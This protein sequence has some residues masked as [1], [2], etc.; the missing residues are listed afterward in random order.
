MQKTAVII[1]GNPEL[2]E[3]NLD[4]GVFYAEL[5]DFLTELGFEVFLDPGAEF[6][7]PQEANVW[8]GHSR[9][10]DRLRFA[11]AG[12]MVIGI[13]VPQNLGDE[14]SEENIF[15]I[16]NHPEDEMVKRLFRDGEVVEGKSDSELDDTYHYVLSEEMK[17]ELKKILEVRDGE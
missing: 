12:T 16:V 7:S 8:I 6:T 15:P 11:P 13:G 3:D 1:Q 4:A 5:T 9:G 2:I 17:D 10:A 14:G